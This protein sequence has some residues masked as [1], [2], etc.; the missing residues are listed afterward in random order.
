[1]ATR[2]RLADEA[3]RRWQAQSHSLGQELRT[4]RRIR[5]VTQARLG[6]SIGVS[7]SQISRREHGKARRFGGDEL[8]VHAAAIG[9][10]LSIKLWPVGGG[11]R[12][13]GQARYVGELA[14][15]IGSAWRVMLEAPIPI[16]GDLRAVDILL[17]RGDVRVAIEVETRLVDLQ[18]QIRAARLK[19]RDAG[20]DRLIL[21]IAGTHANRAVLASARSAI[22][23]GLETDTRYLL[24]SLASGRD[25]GRRRSRQRAVGRARAVRARVRR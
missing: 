17:R 21:A 14:R 10:R 12:D 24:G 6:A 23:G 1:M 7:Q 5:G 19:A 4:A 8:A 13:E 3:R 22:E 25:P 16:P 20:A 18:A 2:I 9:L 15:R 11:L